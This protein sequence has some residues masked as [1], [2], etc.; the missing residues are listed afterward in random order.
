MNYETH[1]NSWIIPNG[2]RFPMEPN[3]IVGVALIID[4]CQTL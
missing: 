3:D 1:N 4:T 2:E